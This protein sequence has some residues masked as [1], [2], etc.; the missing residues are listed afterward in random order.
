MDLLT[1]Q[2]TL[3]SIIVVLVILNITTL[4]FLW[5]GRP[6]KPLLDAP[7]PPNTN[8]FLTKEMGLAGEQ[9]IAFNQL[10]ET[11]FKT[12]KKMNEAI[13]RKRNEMREESLKDDTNKD[14]IERIA[15]EI[16][17]LHYEF[18]KYMFSHFT[19]VKQILNKDQIK[20]FNKLIEKAL[21]R[22]HS[23]HSKGD[24]KHPNRFPIPQPPE[25]NE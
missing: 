6:L 13:N 12:M 19:E 24:K 18:E 10:H 9:E 11:H 5:F 25:N 14:N 3:I 21:A 15:S 4:L 8:Q 20:I 1:K 7:S 2:K 16:G 23:V 22:K 17:N